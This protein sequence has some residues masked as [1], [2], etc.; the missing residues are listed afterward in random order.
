MDA[1]TE[2][3]GGNASPKSGDLSVCLNCGEMLLF[4]DDMKVDKLT[5]DYFSALDEELKRTLRKARR[6]IIERGAFK[7]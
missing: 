6:I 7:P 1:A 4:R 3:G 2:V 5:P